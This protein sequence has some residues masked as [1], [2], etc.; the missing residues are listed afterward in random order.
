MSVV[1][2]RQRDLTLPVKID[3]REM[4]V[5]LPTAIF[6]DGAD[7][8]E[9]EQASKMLG[10]A[11]EGLTT[12]PGLV[13]GSPDVKARVAGGEKLDPKEAL[14]I[15]RQ[16]VTRAAQLT[17]GPISI[18]VLADMETP[19]EEMLRQALNYK[20]WI[21]NAVIKFPITHNG[22]AAAQIYCREHGPVN[23]T[24]NFSQEQGA[25]VYQATLGATYRVFISPFIGRINDKGI[26]GMSLIANLLKMYNSGDGHVTVLVASL[27]NVD[28]LYRT[29][30]L[31]APAATLPFEKVFKPWAAAGFMVPDATYQ[32]Q[33]QGE[34]IPYQDI[35]LR[36]PW[37][38]YNIIHE[39]TKA[40]VLDFYTKW[41]AIVKP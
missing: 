7:T 33:P 37:Q 21:P 3:R 12:N 20:D 18:Q 15:Y 35:S 10:F 25:A 41:A 39:Q 28:Q 22:L 23:L 24:L 1:T 38:S 8:T 32:Y 17:R 4:P 34:V 36:E 31:G 27:R 5:V 2:F 6:I 26:D 9:V 19:S 11:A 30:Q 16:I 40:G 13:A 14:G 29:M